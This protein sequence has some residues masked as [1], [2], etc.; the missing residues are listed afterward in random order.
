MAMFRSNLPMGQAVAKWCG[1]YGMLSGRGGIP[2]VESL[3]R[4]AG[5]APDVNC[6]N[7]G[8]QIMTVTWDVSVLC[9]LDGRFVEIRYD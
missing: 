9:T 4:L 3:L 6:E 7:L 5:K 1:S 2:L 8:S